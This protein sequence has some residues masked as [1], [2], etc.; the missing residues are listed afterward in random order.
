MEN[1]KFEINDLLNFVEIEQL[2]LSVRPI[3]K[4]II[5][6][7][8]MSNYLLINNGDF[9]RYD[10]EKVLFIKED[11]DENY[12]MSLITLF[13][14]KS[15]MNLTDRDK[16][17]LQLKY[18]KTY[19]NI[20]KNSDVNKYLPQLTTYLTNNKVNFSDPHL[21]QIHFQNGFYDFKTGLFNKRIK[22]THFINVHIKRDY[23]KP[24]NDDVIKVH[25]TINKIYPNKEDRDYL[26]MT[27]GLSLTGKSCSDQTM[28]FLIGVGSTGKSTIMELC[29]LSLEDYIFTLP[30][31]TFTKGY[32]KIDKVLNT[33]AKRPYIRISHINEAE[34]AKID[35]SLFKDH[36]D[37]KI[38]TTSLYKDGSNDFQHYSKMVFTSNTFPNIKIDSGTVR[39]VDSYT[40]TSKFTKIQKEICPENH[41]YHAYTDLLK[42]ASTDEKYLNAFFIFLHYLDLIG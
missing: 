25:Q 41:V 2:V 39:R 29:K 15:Y 16:E 10:T 26:L 24:H 32:A 21:Y 27:L 38:Q 37:G 3:E 4:A 9:Y 30:K 31:Q 14:D 11:Y 7:K 19:D 20:F 17:I 42:D 12:I 36:C 13:I 6:S 22:G 33:Y 18:K 35:D 34:D 40:H 5:I 28:L 8:K 1:I 23:V